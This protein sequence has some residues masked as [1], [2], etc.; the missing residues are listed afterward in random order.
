MSRDNPAPSTAPTM[1]NQLRRGATYVAVTATSN[2]TGEYLGVET[3]H[4]VWAIL[5]RHECG[6][7]SIP[8]ASIESIV[9]A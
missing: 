7:D 4:G 2:A 3:T 1:L 6:T 8:L 9:A 5:L